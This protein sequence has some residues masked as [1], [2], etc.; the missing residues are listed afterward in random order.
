MNET[1]ESFIAKS[2]VKSADLE[3]R[4]KIN[5][6]IGKYNAVVP[7]G[8]LQFKNITVAR[9]SAK[10]AK[11]RS[12]ETLDQQLEE[13]ERQFTGRGGKVIWAGDA[14]E[15]LSAIGKICTEKECKIVVKS[16]SMATE[17]ID[18]NA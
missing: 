2:T 17:E 1:A 9:E 15:A 6:N 12:I 8:K 4:R 3:H 16:K 5:F 11:W 10:N 7:V 18:L 14:E 13:F